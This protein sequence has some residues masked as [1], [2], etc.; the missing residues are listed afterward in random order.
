MPLRAA[1]RTAPPRSNA[2]RLLGRRATRAAREVPLQCC[3]HKGLFA[4]VLPKV[5]HN[6]VILFQSERI[7]ALEPIAVRPALPPPP[8]PPPQYTFGASAPL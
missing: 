3:T 1:L 5:L 6:A 2:W 8:P 4:F 7:I